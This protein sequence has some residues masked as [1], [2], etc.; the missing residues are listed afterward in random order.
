MAIGA[1][2]GLGRGLFFIFVIFVVTIREVKAISALRL[3]RGVVGEIVFNFRLVIGPGIKWRDS[4]S[5]C[6]VVII[7]AAVILVQGIA[8]AGAGVAAEKCRGPLGTSGDTVRVGL[9]R[10][11]ILGGEP[12]VASGAWAWYWW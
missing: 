9:C 6:G 11:A 4:C 12:I 10:S 3:S 1:S 5:I 2:H 7:I 8:R